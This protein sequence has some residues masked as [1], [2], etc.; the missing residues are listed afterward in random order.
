MILTLRRFIFYEFGLILQN[1]NNNSEVSVRHVEP[2]GSLSLSVRIHVVN[3]SSGRDK[4]VLI[5]TRQLTLRAAL[6]CVLLSDR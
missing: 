1:D 6:G 4:P 2:R 3:R 5:R